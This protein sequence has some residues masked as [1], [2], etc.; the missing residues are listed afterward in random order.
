MKTK[1]RHR[2]AAAG[3]PL[4]LTGEGRD[5]A[6]S[7]STKSRIK[8]TRD[9]VTIPLPRKFNLYNP[10]GPNMS[11]EVRAVSRAELRILEENLVLL[12]DEELDR[13]VPAHLRNRGE[14]GGRVSSLRLRPFHTR[15]TP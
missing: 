15:P 14:I 8:V 12:I 7:E 9:S 11:E 2:P 13:A 1:A 3:L 6:L 5:E 4:V 10:Q